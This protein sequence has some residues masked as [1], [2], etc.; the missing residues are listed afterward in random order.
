VIF[1]LSAYCLLLTASCT[2]VLVVVVV[3]VDGFFFDDIQ[4]DG[5]EADDFQLNSTVV[6]IND[7]AF[8]RIGIH[9]DIS[10]AIRTR[11]GRHFFYL[12]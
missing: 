11:S 10:F 4:L 12:Q 1:R 7:V 5:I 3:I 9:V 2:S 6:T 8:V